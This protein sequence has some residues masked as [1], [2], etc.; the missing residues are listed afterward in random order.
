MAEKLTYAINACT[1]SIAPWIVWQEASPIAIINH[2]NNNMQDYKIYANFFLLKTSRYILSL[3]Q[4]V[5]KQ[6]RAHF[7]ASDWRAHS[8]GVWL[9]LSNY[10]KFKLDSCNWTPTC[11]HFNYWYIENWHMENQ[12]QSSTQKRLCFWQWC[13][14]RVGGGGYLTNV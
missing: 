10:R 6:L 1:P 7:S 9:Q 12:S 11:P 8:V 14:G 13:T 5:E 4:M 2:I 3:L